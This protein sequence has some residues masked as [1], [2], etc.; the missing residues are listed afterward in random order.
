ML[1]FP[2]LIRKLKIKIKYRYSFNLVHYYFTILSNV[3][4]YFRLCVWVIRPPVP[5]PSYPALDPRP[6]AL[7][8]VSSSSTSM[9]MCTLLSMVYGLFKPCWLIGV[10][11]T[12]FKET[13]PLFNVHL[14][15]FVHFILCPT[16]KYMFKVNNKKNWLICWLM[17]SKFKVNTA[18]HRS[19]VLLLTFTTVS[20]SI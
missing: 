19:G 17:C 5:W 20:I 14:S 13:T 3:Q 2:I 6:T 12:C 15:C 10:S 4:V 16:D 11:S 1:S 7:I 8:K 18:W 9:I